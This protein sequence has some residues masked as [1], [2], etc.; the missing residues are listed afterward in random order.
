MANA[1]A[2]NTYYIDTQYSTNEELAGK[3]L[4]VLGVIMSSTNTNAVLVLT[5]SG[6]SK[7]D[8]RIAASG[9]S[10]HFDFSKSPILFSTSVRPT[11]LTNAKATVILEETRTG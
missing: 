9:E 4:K 11:T 8:F 2:A 5:D 3:N 1:R 7:L 6:T 10:K